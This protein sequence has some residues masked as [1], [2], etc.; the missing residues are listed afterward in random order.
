MGDEQSPEYV[1][2]RG[3]QL[4]DI[5]KQ[6]VEQIEPPPKAFTIESLAT[7]YQTTKQLIDKLPVDDRYKQVQLAHLNARYAALMQSLME[8]LQP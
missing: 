5:I 6:H 2:E 1:E 7:W 3:R 8:A 4:Q